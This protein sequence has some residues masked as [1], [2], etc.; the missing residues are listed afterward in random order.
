MFVYGNRETVYPRGIAE[1]IPLATPHG[2][3]SDALLKTTGLQ[4]DD[5]GIPDAGA[6]AHRVAPAHNP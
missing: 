5:R 4:R 1:A 3:L 6:L 2:H